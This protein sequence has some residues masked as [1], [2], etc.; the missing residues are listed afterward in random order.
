MP[1]FSLL[2]C[3]IHSFLSSSLIGFFWFQP[4][5]FGQIP[6]VLDSFQV[7]YRPLRLWGSLNRA[8]QAGN[9]LTG[10]LCT[11][12]IYS[13]IG[14]SS[15]SS[16]QLSHSQLGV[17]SDPRAFS[18]TPDH[19]PPQHPE[20]F[21]ILQ[22]MQVCNESESWVQK[23]FLGPQCFYSLSPS[24]LYLLIPGQIASHGLNPI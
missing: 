3:L 19:S 24:S 21:F 8:E 15:S 6:A 10:P 7:S 14:S 11:V 5:Q 23:T 17:H 4:L 13:L 1:S 9:D 12:A 16:N 2:F 18:A 20:L 22:T